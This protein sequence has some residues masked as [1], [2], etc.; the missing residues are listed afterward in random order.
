MITETISV[1]E[2]ITF[3]LI[4]L[5]I[6]IALIA[7]VAVL[8]DNYHLH[9]RPDFVK[10]GPRHLLAKGRIRT[11]VRKLITKVLF[12][13]AVIALMTVPSR[14]GNTLT[15]A[16][17]SLIV[18]I[19]AT[20]TMMIIDTLLYLIERRKIIHQIVEVVDVQHEQRTSST[21][22]IEPDGTGTLVAPVDV[23][24]RN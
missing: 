20:I 23:E 7:C 11:E 5:G 9:R 12:L 22:I 21:V 10:G 13:N 2:L 19:L 17:A 14:E 4:A 3:I 1:L 18:A 6:P 15:Y 16:S 8:Y 24:M